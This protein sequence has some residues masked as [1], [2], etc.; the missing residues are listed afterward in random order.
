M[1][2][3]RPDVPDLLAN[4]L[5]YVPVGLALRSRGRRLALATIALVSVIAETSQLFAAG[6]HA[7][8]IDL[9]TNII[10]GSIGV[11][12]AISYLEGHDIG[13]HEL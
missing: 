5:G 3:T 13:V 6:R 9:A 4:V 7:G 11:A 12:I 1:N 10:G 8:L 2:L